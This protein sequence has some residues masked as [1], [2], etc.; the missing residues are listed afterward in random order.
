[1]VYHGISCDIQYHVISVSCCIMWYHVISCGI[2][3]VRL[4]DL[5]VRGFLMQRD[6]SNHVTRG[7]KLTSASSSEL[8]ASLYR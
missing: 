4:A 7:R 8:S 5:S 1:M 2:K 3:R 6:I